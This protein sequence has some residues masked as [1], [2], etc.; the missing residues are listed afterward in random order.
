MKDIHEFVKELPLPEYH[1]KALS[2]LF[3]LG[4]AKPQELAKV[5][6]VPRT[7]IYDVLDDLFRMGL[8]Q[9]NPG[10][11]YVYF[12]TDP[13]DI[14]KNFMLW[15]ERKFREEVKHLKK[16]TKKIKKA[17]LSC[18]RSSPT[19]LLRVVQV[20]IPSEIM[21][22]EIIEKA[23]NEIFIISR[24]FEYYWRVRKALFSSYKRNLRIYLLLL[25][26]ELLEEGDRRRQ[27]LIVGLIRKDMPKI[28]IKFSK[29][30]LPIRATIVDA[31]EDY[32]SGFAVFS[33]EQTGVPLFMREAAVTSN[34]SLVYG[35][36]I[37]AK[38]LWEKAKK[39]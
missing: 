25:H 31:N 5:S 20:G 12:V 37:Y 23:K 19:E 6:G 11:Q 27:K 4:K 17:K 39:S 14:I 30:K 21:T 34:P 35:L 36:K 16:L 15:K 18:Y 13:K 22:A 1:K 38:S 33:C 9:K 3:I 8:V 26:P 32:S 7:R 24:A 2:Y 28:E 10:Q 29:E